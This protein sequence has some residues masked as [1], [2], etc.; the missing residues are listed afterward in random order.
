MHKVFEKDYFLHKLIKQYQEHGNIIIAYDF[1]DTV[2]DYCTHEPI[3]EI[4]DLLQQLNK[5]ANVKLICYTS[6]IDN[7]IEYVKNFLSNNQIPYTTINEPVFVEGMTSGKI[8]YNILID[9]K[10]G[11]IE[12]Y[13][14][15]NDFLN[16][17]K[18]NKEIIYEQK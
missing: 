17:I 5:N 10:S 6:R 2:H 18:E 7:E 12:T 15:L 3:N 14:I 4:I 8:Y 13:R 11:I 9:D 1:D 16:Y